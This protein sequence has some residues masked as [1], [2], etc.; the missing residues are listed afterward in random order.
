[1]V[2]VLMFRV[3]PEL[4]LQHAALEPGGELQAGPRETRTSTE[5]RGA[6]GAGG[7][8]QQSGRTE[9]GKPGPNV[10]FYL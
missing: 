4:P 3:S 6:G 10:D 5:E 9:A 2:V 8:L 7:T 1:M